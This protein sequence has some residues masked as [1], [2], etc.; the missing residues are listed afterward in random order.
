M[1]VASTQLHNLGHAEEAISSMELHELALTSLRT[2]LVGNQQ[3][4]EE[5]IITTLMM[6]FLE[7]SCSQYRIAFSNF[8]I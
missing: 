2:Y 8:T 6:G 4:P 7:V 1:A 5:T 3:S